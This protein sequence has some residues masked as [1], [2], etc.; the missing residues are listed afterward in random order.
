MIILSAVF[1]GR[2]WCTICP[3]ELITFLAAKIGL[4]RKAPV[5]LKSGWVIT[6]IS[7]M[8]MGIAIGLRLLVVRKL[9]AELVDTEGWRS[10]LLYLIPGLY[11]GAFFVM[12]IG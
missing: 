1:L 11:G 3:L 6:V 7:L 8:I 4:K 9:I 10:M 5:F 12:L 2:V